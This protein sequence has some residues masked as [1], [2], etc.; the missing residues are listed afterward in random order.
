[1]IINPLTGLLIRPLILGIS[2]I[3]FPRTNNLN[4]RTTTMIMI[5]RTKRTPTGTLMTPSMTSSERPFF[6]RIIRPRSQHGTKSTRITISNPTPRP[7]LRTRRPLNRVTTSIHNSPIK[8]RSH[9]INSIIRPIRVTIHHLHSRKRPSQSRRSIKLVI[10]NQTRINTIQPAKIRHK[11]GSQRCRTI[12]AGT[13][14]LHTQTNILRVT[15]PA[16]TPQTTKL[17]IIASILPSKPDRLTLILSRSKPRLNPRS[18]RLSNLVSLTRNSPS[19]RRQRIRRLSTMTHHSLN[20]HIIQTQHLQHRPRISRQN[21]GTHKLRHSIR[22]SSPSRRRS[23]T[24]PQTYITKKRGLINTRI[25][26]P[27]SQKTNRQPTLTKRRLPTLSTLHKPRLLR[28][29]SL[30][31]RRVRRDKPEIALRNRSLTRSQLRQQSHLIRIR[32][33][34]IDRKRPHIRSVTIIILIHSPHRSHRQDPAR[35]RK[36][37]R[38]NTRNPPLRIGVEV[39]IHR[40]PQQCAHSLIRVSPNRPSDLRT[41]I[42]TRRPAPIHNRH[43]RNR[44]QHIHDTARLNP[45]TATSPLHLNNHIRQQKLSLNHLR[46]TRLLHH[47]ASI[48]TRPVSRKP[49]CAILW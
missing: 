26:R 15:H 11:P 48:Q 17:R 36:L 4:H 13:L 8:T 6:G 5:L 35:L 43:Q 2:P 24:P 1:M 9:R 14:Q 7:T 39:T 27:G 31:R 25:K 22:R 40:L 46:I 47:K 33:R 49:A 29:Q 38:R 16:S 34:R 30:T 44:T 18:H 45:L 12:M 41:A 28:S 19:Q 10:H 21:T 3:W 20:L 42:N 23:I 32:C 37:I